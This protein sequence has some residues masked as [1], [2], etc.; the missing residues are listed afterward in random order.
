MGD[1]ILCKIPLAGTPYYMDDFGINIYSLEELSHL[2]F[3]HTD[4]LSEDIMTGDFTN[5]VGE[6]L[7]LPAL[8][9]ELDDLIAE[10][11]SLHIFVGR[12]LSNCGYLTESDL[13]KTI[14]RIQALEN[15]SEAEIRKIRA[16]RLLHS[17]RLSDAVL[18]YTSILEDR[19]NLKLSVVNEGDVFYNL[20]VC[21]SR[22]FFFEEA[23]ECF[24]SAY[25]KNR[26]TESIKALLHCVLL[27]NDENAF[28]AVVDRYLVPPDLVE[29][30]K[31]EFNNSINSSSVESFKAKVEK[32]YSQDP[33]S[34][35]ALVGIWE[36]EYEKN[37]GI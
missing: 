24:N 26:R 1:L 6:E 25:E 16:D 7:H 19:K 11:A 35:A 34:L 14:D 3:K 21:Y 4:M 22:M 23:K 8:K 32:A 12:L 33:K 13:K 27:M 30:V 28:K 17:D 15:K 18:E 5:W 31:D 10:G 36:S 9:R 37:S 20:G 2:A 29:V